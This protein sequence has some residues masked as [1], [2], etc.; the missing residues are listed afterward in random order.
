MKKDKRLEAQRTGWFFPSPLGEEIAFLASA[1]DK[2]ESWQ[3]EPPF[4]IPNEVP[5]VNPE[6]ADLAPASEGHC[7]AWDGVSGCRGHSAAKA[8]A[9]LA[10]VGVHVVTLQQRP[11]LPPNPKR[12]DMDGLDC[13][14]SGGKSYHLENRLK[15]YFRP[16]VFFF[17][18]LVGKE[19]RTPESC[20]SD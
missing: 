6:G 2:S 4:I 18:I 20:S 14:C 13:F 10:H 19:I 11:L 15:K 9:A 3:R 17:L 12:N 1:A 7:S 8:E 16:F 5:S